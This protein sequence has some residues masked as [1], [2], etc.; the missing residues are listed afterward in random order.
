MITLLS[1]L[2]F[3]LLCR[4][5]CV[6]S[7]LLI[8]FLM[9]FLWLLKRR[10][11]AVS[12]LPMYCRLRIFVRGHCLFRE[13]NSFLRAKLEE[14][15]ELRATDNVKGHI[16]EHIFAAKFII[17]RFEKL[18]NILGYYVYMYITTMLRRG[19]ELWWIYSEAGS[20]EVYIHRSS[21]TLRGIVV[22]VFIKSDA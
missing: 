14:N 19:G 13:A 2:Y 1:K 17:H 3:R 7:Q 18:G 22:L 12:L 8:P 4:K 9:W 20:V 10:L 11:N 21:P 5:C 15:C 16:S 6:R